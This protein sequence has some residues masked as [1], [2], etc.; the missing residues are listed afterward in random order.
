M[1]EEVD[2]DLAEITSRIDARKEQGMTKS[3]DLLI[4]LGRS[5][6]Y[7]NPEFWAAKVMSG[8]LSK[9]R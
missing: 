1:V 8:R 2:G 9:L 3:L 5:K 7:K 6:G 4:K